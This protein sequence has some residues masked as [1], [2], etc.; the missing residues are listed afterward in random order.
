MLRDLRHALRTLARAPVYTATVV[1]TLGLGIGGTIAVFSVLRSVI[2]EP[3]AWAPT[4][5]VMSIAER[6]S[7]DNIRPASYPTFQDWRAGTDAFE[8]MAFVRGQGAVLK[9]PDGAERLLGAFVTDEYF[10]VLPGRA[11]VGRALEPSDFAPGAPLV[12]AISW[13]LW[14]RRFGGERSV[15]GRNVTLGE[16]SYTI[17]GVMPVGFVYPVWADLWMPITAILGTSPALQQ[18]GVHADSRVVGRLRAGVDSAAGVQALSAVA[19]H[20]AEAYPAENGGWSSVALQPVAAEI[21]GGTGSQLRLLTA[22]ATFVLLIA[23][24]NVAAL[25]LARAAA[26]SRELAIRTALGGGR[27]ALIRLLAAECV[28]LGVAAG[29]LGLGA[30]ALLVRRLRV[31]GRDLL[32]RAAELTVDPRGMVVVVALSIV[33][34]VVLGLLPALRRE[35]LAGALREGVGAGARPVRRRLRGALVVG[36]IALA[37]VL[38]TGAGLLVRSLERLQRVPTGMDE[39]RLLAVSIM[40]WSSKYENPEHALQLYREVAR[41]VAALPGVQAVTLTNHVPLSGAS[42]TTPLEVEGAPSRESDEAL[43]RIVDTA[44]FRTTGIPVVRGR[45]LTA[46]DMRHPGD[47]VLVNQ[48]LATRYWPGGDA[49]GKRITVRKSAQGR[50]DFGEPVRATI[51]GVVGDVRHY[52]LDTDIVPEVYLPYTLTVWG[53]MS[54]V[55]RTAGAPEAMVPQV[56]RAVRSVDPDLPLLGGAFFQGVYDLPTALHR[57]LAYRR[58]ITGLLGA[59]ALPALLL[60]ALGI[61]GV[62]SYL[63]T[64]RTREIGIRMALGAQRRDV[65]TLVLGEGMRLAGMGVLIGS[66]GAIATTRW[67]Q[68]ELY[69]TSATDPLTLVLAAA[70]LAGVSLLATLL[71]ARRATA[72]DPARTLQSE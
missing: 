45:G 6:D 30:A 8:G 48:A 49:L 27:G 1:L 53:W 67:L 4:D 5:R 43:F 9:T 33:L 65:L 69:E 42:I 56:T 35:S 41:T 34:V 28:V 64:Q 21:L 71:P 14:Q 10:R 66:L 18:R 59:F 29:G 52:S 51:V 61:Y 39:D 38:V 54:L 70:T 44:Y 62:V 37:L 11:A 7:A 72:I 26:R 57:S 32:P 25:T 60:A 36:E 3:F 24:I 47:A 22:A 58:F 31:G 23:C 15:V 40:P 12:A 2:L 19:A 68:S 17:V 63:L 13:S 55:V 46:D 50:P 20:L 16:Q